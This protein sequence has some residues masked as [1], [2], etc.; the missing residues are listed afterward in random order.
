MTY[1]EPG[2]SQLRRGKAINRCQDDICDR[3][4]KD[5]EVAIITMLQEVRQNALEKNGNLKSLSKE[6]EDIIKI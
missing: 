1:E 2:K 3:I 6:I 4:I 5:S